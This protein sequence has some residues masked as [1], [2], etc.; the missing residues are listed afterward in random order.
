MTDVSR[1]DDHRGG[2]GRPEPLVPAGLAQLLAQLKGPHDYWD[3]P[4][5][6]FG[7]LTDTYG[8]SAEQRA[9][10]NSL[11]RLGSKALLGGELL[12]AAQWLG[13]ASEAGHPG[14]LFRLAALAGRAGYGRREDVLFLVAEAARHGH[15]DA[16]HL[17]AATAHR[18]P[19]TP[20]WPVEDPQF[21]EEIRERLGVSKHLLTPEP[22]HDNSA[23][24]AVPAVPAS[25]ADGSGGPRLV[26]V[27]PPMFPS[28]DHPAADTGTQ[29]GPMTD[30]PHLTALDG[31]QSGALILPLPDPAPHLAAAAA[32]AAAAARADAVHMEDG[33][34]DP[35]SANALR[36]AILT[37]MAR[38]PSLPTQPPQEQAIAIRARDLLHHIQHSGGIS[39][40]DLARRTG[41]SV[42]STA[43]LLHWLRA[44]YLVETIAGAHLPGPVMEMA[45]RPELHRQLMQ[46]TLDGLRDQLGAAVYLSAYTDGDINILQSS[47]SDRAPAVRPGAP[48]IETGHASAVGKAHLADLDFDARLEHLTRYKPVPL[49][50]RTITDP[51][52]LFDNLDGHGPHA[53]Q[54]DLFEYSTHNLCAAISLTLPGTDA[55]CIAL[56]L[57]TDQH[58]RLIRTAAA[59]SQAS[60]GLLLARLLTTTATRMTNTPTGGEP[61]S[62]ED[63]PTPP[64]IALP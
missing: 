42:A 34:S 61:W 3:R 35:W 11:Y 52:I 37:D 30:R 51:R 14:A 25:P 45:D 28:P 31:R 48:F 26:L 64:A 43:W 60:T 55:T 40:R 15:G 47:H 59:L 2:A 56:A 49:T 10:A 16:R 58:H 39:T 24:A 50:R 22:D 1:Y 8:L 53:P 62:T 63:T 23:A 18:R 41:M 19:T 46:Q 29:S 6:Y 38:S 4:D 5:G 32:G 57:P 27:P 54:L 21:F 33:G 36:P 12:R 20:V 9:H 13:E 17:L 7:P 44:Q